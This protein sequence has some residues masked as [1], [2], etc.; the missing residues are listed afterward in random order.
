VLEAQ[1][2]IGNRDGV[3]FTSF[4]LTSMAGGRNDLAEA[5]RRLLECFWVAAE[6]GFVDPNAYAR[7]VASEI[8]LAI[9][10]SE[11]AATLLGAS[12]EGFDRIGGTPWAHDKGTTRAHA[13]G[14]AGTLGRPGRRPRHRALDRGR[15]L[16]VDEAVALAAALD[17]RE[18]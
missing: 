10:A 2:H 15:A 4:A 18:R 7:A 17:T 5:R 8:A 14:A 16:R 11:Q 3:A 9:G 13:H 1:R 6:V 12:Q